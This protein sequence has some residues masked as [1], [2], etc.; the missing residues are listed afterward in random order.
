MVC[1]GLDEHHR[2]PSI[3]IKMGWVGV[4]F[5]EALRLL[6]SFADFCFLFQVLATFGGGS[7]PSCKEPNTL[8]VGRLGGSGGAFT[9]LHVVM[10][11]GWFL[12]HE[13]P[14]LL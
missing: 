4:F 14:L 11:A 6:F 8:A 13:L 5:L 9:F 12:Q 3:R 2:H 1:R 7:A 10:G